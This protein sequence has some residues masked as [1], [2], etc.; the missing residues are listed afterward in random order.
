MTSI[1]ET[2]A[3]LTSL[4]L[5][6]VQRFNLTEQESFVCLGLLQG[7][8]LDDMADEFNI[9]RV[10]LRQQFNNLLLKTGTNT[11]AKLVT[12]VLSRGFGAASSAV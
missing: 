8:S 11:E 3:G 12:K 6:I 2:S 7:K 9:S 5:A 10:I 1:Y 4:P